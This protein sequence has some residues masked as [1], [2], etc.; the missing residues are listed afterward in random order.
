MVFGALIFDSLYF[1]VISVNTNLF[2]KA[3]PADDK[4]AAIEQL[5][6]LENTFVATRNSHQSKV[7]TCLLTLDGACSI[8]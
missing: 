2:L 8:T 4:A 5:D 7:S 3:A 6:W 1:S